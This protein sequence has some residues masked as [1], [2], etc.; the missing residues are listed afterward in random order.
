M[1]R[2]C[3]ERHLEGE[4][5]EGPQV[6]GRAGAGAAPA[7]A[8]LLPPLRRAVLPVV[9][10]HPTAA[11]TALRRFPPRTPAGV[12]DTDTGSVRLVQAGGKAMQCTAGRMQQ[13]NRSR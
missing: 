5:V 12:P 4:G 1:G 6:G 3:S 2:R 10:P 11:G 13:M 7:A 8:L 9:P